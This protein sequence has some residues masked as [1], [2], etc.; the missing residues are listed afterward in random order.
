MSGLNVGP[1]KPATDASL[2]KEV[3]KIVQAPSQWGAHKI[4][5]VGGEFRLQE[6]WGFINWLS[7]LLSK[8]LPALRE[9][10]VNYAAQDL[11]KQ[12][13]KILTQHHITNEK[14]TPVDAHRKAEQEITDLFHQTL[15][16]PLPPTPRPSTEA[17]SQT[18]LISRD[19]SLV[20]T[21]LDLRTFEQDFPGFELPEDYKTEPQTVTEESAIQI[22]MLALAEKYK[23]QPLPQLPTDASIEQRNLWG[24]IS[25]LN[26]R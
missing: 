13:K 9:W 26:R 1:F 7:N 10:Y 14:M 11:T 15:P 23:N 16:P 17:P 4:V 6:R 18:R 19:G 8:C 21:A 2:G 25:Q 24:T 3:K 20:F 5:R 22:F 12:Y